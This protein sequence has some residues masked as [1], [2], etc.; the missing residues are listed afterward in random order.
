MLTGSIMRGAV[1]A[2]FHG[3]SLNRDIHS[4]SPFLVPPPLL[5]KDYA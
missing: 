1:N 3:N 5:D 2:R 4:H